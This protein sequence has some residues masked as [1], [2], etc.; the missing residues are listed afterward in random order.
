MENKLMEILVDPVSG[1]RFKSVKSPAQKSS[2]LNP[3]IVSSIRNSSKSFPVQ[4][5]IPIML[6][7]HD[8]NGENRT[9]PL[10][11]D[12][13][14]YF[15]DMWDIR[16]SK[17]VRFWQDDGYTKG[18]CRMEALEYAGHLGNKMVLIVGAG[19]GHEA[20]AFQNMGAWTLTTD[21]LYDGLSHQY[22]RGARAVMDAEHMYLL[23]ECFDV[24]YAQSMLMFVDKSKVTSEI[25]RVLKPGGLF[26]SVEP[27]SGGMTF[28]LIYSAL[29]KFKHY[30]HLGLNPPGY[31]TMNDF[32][33]L[34]SLFSSEVYRSFRVLTPI[35]HIFRILKLNLITEAYFRFE[36]I[37]LSVFPGLKKQCM[38]AIHV[39]RK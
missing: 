10:K 15:K 22:L 37:W 30:A 17:G 27:L 24:V 33:R 12:I 1:E 26:I 20:A 14:Q 18:R 7:A 28:R 19:R 32:N 31:M 2:R 35:Y 29:N 38:F 6:D 9:D 39:L 21:I 23:S 5:G 34:R 36:K 16:R 4:D 13:K 8:L 3:Q 25:L 11:D